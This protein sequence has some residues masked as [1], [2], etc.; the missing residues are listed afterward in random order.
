[1]KYFFF[2]DGKKETFFLTIATEQ[3]DEEEHK[4]YV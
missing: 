2:E 4:K 3:F 1:L